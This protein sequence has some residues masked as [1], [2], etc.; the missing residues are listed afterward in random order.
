MLVLEPVLLAVAMLATD[1]RRSSMSYSGVS[2]FP[3]DGA[4]R[5]LKG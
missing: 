3:V 4:E 5:K 1:G 2:W